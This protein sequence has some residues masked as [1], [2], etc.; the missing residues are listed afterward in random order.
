VEVIMTHKK[1]SKN[2]FKLSLNF[3]KEKRKEW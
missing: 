1:K 3:L 2:M